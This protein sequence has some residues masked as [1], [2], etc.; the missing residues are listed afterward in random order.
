M[1]GALLESTEFPNDS[2]VYAYILGQAIKPSCFIGGSYYAEYSLANFKRLSRE[3]KNR[4]DCELAAIHISN[5][6]VSYMASKASQ[7]VETMFRPNN[8]AIERVRKMESDGVPVF[9][10]QDT[11]SFEQVYSYIEETIWEEVE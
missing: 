10:M 2:G 5:K 9:N 8:D 4:I 3:I 11:E 7:R 6:T 1:P